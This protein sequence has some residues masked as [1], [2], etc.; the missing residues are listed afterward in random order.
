VDAALRRTLRWGDEVRL[1]ASGGVVEGEPPF[2]ALRFVG[3]TRSLRGYAINEFPTRRSAAISLDYALG[4]DI[5]RVVPLLGRLRLQLVPFADAAALFRL[6]RRDGSVL[7]P[8]RPPW[9]FSA[10]SG[11]QHNALGIPGGSGQVRLDVARRFDRARDAW[12]FRVGLTAA[13]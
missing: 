2:Q 3:G 8:G 4:T 12:S 5:L 11:V 7:D 1:R 9:R 10:G 6:Q 13:R